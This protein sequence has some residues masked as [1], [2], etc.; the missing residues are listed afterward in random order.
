MTPPAFTADAQPVLR[1]LELQAAYQ[2]GYL[3]GGIAMARTCREFAGGANRPRGDSS[4]AELAALPPADAP[5]A[6][7]T[8]S[9]QTNP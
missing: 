6:T 5:P 8:K 9:D 3:A 1:D 4:P 2:R 7:L